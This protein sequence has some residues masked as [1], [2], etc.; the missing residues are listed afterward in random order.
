MPLPN[1]SSATLAQVIEYC[2]YNVDA[3]KTGDDGSTRSVTEEQ[4]KAW[5]EEFVKVDQGV[6]FELLLV[7]E[8]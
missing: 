5:A 4:A 3:K 7:R 1:V 8:F 6:L 2:K